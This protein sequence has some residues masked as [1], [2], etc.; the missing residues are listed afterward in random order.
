MICLSNLDYLIVD[1]WKVIEIIPP[2]F[3]GNVQKY[4]ISPHPEF[5][6]FDFPFLVCS[7]FDS[8]VLINVKEYSLSKFI[9]ASCNTVRSQQAFFFQKESY[10]YS[11]HFARNVQTEAFLEHQ[12]W[13]QMELKQDFH[14]ELRLYG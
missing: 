2:L 7:G 8:Y 6:E 3:K 10:G 9:D 14:D 11:I 12:M 13:Y 4:F 5:N 1:R